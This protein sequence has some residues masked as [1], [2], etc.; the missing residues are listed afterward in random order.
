MAKDLR[1][2]VEFL[3]ARRDA[4][5]WLEKRPV[6]LREDD[7]LLEAC[8]AF[9]RL[10]L[11][12]E[13]C[14]TAEEIADLEEVAGQVREELHRAMEEASCEG[15]LVQRCRDVGLDREEAEMFL[16]LLTSSFGLLGPN[17]WIADLEDLQVRL[18]PF[19]VPPL[20]TARIMAPGARLVASGL[21]QLT[22]A[23]SPMRAQ[24]AVAP[25]LIQ[26]VWHRC[27]EAAWRFRD[28]EDA[29]EQLRRLT[30]AARRR[31][32]RLEE[33]E[34]VPPEGKRRTSIPYSIR[35]LLRAFRGGLV[36]HEDWPMAQALAE[37]QDR[38]ALL[39][40]LL[41]G[42]EAGHLPPD[43]RLYRGQNLAA[44]MARS[45][46]EARPNLS[47]LRRGG[48]L[49]TRGWIRICGGVPP[50][51]CEEDEA[52]L[53]EADFELGQAGRLALGV[54]RRWRSR[55]GRLRRARLSLDLLV[56]DEATLRELRTI[57]HHARTPG[58]LLDSWGLRRTIPYGS[59]LTLLFTGPPGVG[60]T[61]TAEAL[62]GEL[63]RPLL[64][65]DA[66]VIQSCWVGE[67]EKNI[68]RAF[69]EAADEDAVLFWDEADAFFFD[70]GYASKTWEVREVD[71]LLQ[72]L[73]NHPGLCILA[74]NRHDALDPA[75]RR[76]IG[77][78]VEFRRPDRRRSARI[79][80]TLLPKEVPLAEEIDFLALGNLELSGGEIKNAILRAAR[81]A[82]ATARSCG[83]STQDLLDAARAEV[84]HDSVR[85]IGFSSVPPSEPHAVSP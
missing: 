19:G 74:T 58:D 25:D 47:L 42:R 48:E 45:L 30:A 71:V 67:T 85:T 53:A 54:A 10:A 28:P 64:T 59:G 41:A 60:K 61:A 22:E 78:K 29:L 32:R 76:R 33:D 14:Q 38:E 12:A 40:L 79:W 66:S 7:D 55:S 15:F 62:A 8:C 2:P 3:H 24:I 37:L 23:D 83:L 77:Q 1:P 4:M 11:A 65:V 68:V 80:R 16:L 51:V 81:T 18:R 57:L 56:H 26:R 73:E 70:R 35:R 44:C 13:C 20:R 31:L 63:D 43:H 46:T 21:V 82:R 17:H 52:L 5:A 69:R 34:S 9:F 36:G 49:R 27:E 84:G 75:L 6:L 50:G 72:E 39:L